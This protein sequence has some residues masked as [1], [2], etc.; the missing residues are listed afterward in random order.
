MIGIQGGLNMTNLTAKETF[1]DTKYRNGIL[2]GLNYELL[3][4][5][6]LS[7]ESDILYSQQGFKDVIIFTDA[8]G[9]PLGENDNFKFNYDYLI[10]PLKIGYSFGEKYKLTPRIGICPSILINAKTTLPTFDIDGNQIG[11]ETTDVKDKVNKIDLSGLIE[12][13]GAYVFSNNLELFSSI[14]YRHGITTFSNDDYFKES[15]MRH[16][17]FSLSVGLKIKLNK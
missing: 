6:K 11:T 12:I 1:N 7:F 4:S 3:F 15:K 13:E 10:I 9:N 17:G 8:M 2:I 5:S 14:A 16:F